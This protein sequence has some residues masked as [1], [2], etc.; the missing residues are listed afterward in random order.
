MKI[1]LCLLFLVILIIIYAD[2]ISW[3]ICLIKVHTLSRD[4][5]N[6]EVLRKLLYEVDDILKENEIPY[7]LA[8]GTALGAIREGDIIMEDTDV[9]LGIDTEYKYTFY[10]RILPILYKKGFRLGRGSKHDNSSITTIYKNSEYVDI[11]FTCPSHICYSL[12]DRGGSCLPIM[13]VLKPLNTA[14]IG[15]R[16]FVVPSINYIKFLY[17]E[18]WKTPKKK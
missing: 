10:E 17:G 14:N 1:K 18:D 7:W 3:W 12:E 8:S 5:K 4:Y 11:D 6:Q 16:K 2:K 13:K 15:S 9:D